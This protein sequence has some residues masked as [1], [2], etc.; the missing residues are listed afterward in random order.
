MKSWV[1][2]SLLLM[3]S[4]GIAFADLPDGVWIHYSG[5]LRGSTDPCGCRIPMGGIARRIGVIERMEK[6]AS[7]DLHY[8]VDAGE[9]RELG[10]PVN[11]SLKTAVLLKAMKTGPLAAVNV[12]LRDMMFDIGLIDSL[13]KADSIPF[14]SANLRIDTLQEPLFPPYRIVT[15]KVRN[16]K[17]SVAFIGLS[18][19]SFIRYSNRKQGI[20]ALDWIL[21]LRDLNDELKQKNVDATVLLTDATPGRWD[22]LMTGSAPFSLIIS[23]SSEWN[24]NTLT[25]TKYG[26]VISPMP[27]GKHWEA[28]KSTGKEK[29]V[30]LASNSELTAKEPEAP[31]T[32]KLVTDRKNK[33]IGAQ[34]AKEDVSL[35]PP[36]NT[37]QPEHHTVTIG[38]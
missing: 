17:I 26:P 21:V 9:W 36:L 16:K 28:V 4:A 30:W 20:V 13:S 3:V 31:Q 5:G 6:I 8:Y 23:S 19:P 10:D 12:S 38:K 32:A 33:F 7:A 24:W 37:I 22:S 14:V 25:E 15:G 11:G 2:W 29:T 1:W 27:I 35:S 34:P 18:D